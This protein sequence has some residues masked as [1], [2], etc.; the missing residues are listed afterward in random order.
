L[1]GVERYSYANGEEYTAYPDGTLKATNKA[2]VRIMEFPDKT[3]EILMPDGQVIKLTAEKQVVDV[4][5]GP[6]THR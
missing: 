5:Y 4:S 1:E 6:A 3:K 2:G